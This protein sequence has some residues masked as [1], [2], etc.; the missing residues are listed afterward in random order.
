M[1]GS[2]GLAAAGSL[3]IGL[4]PTYGT[5]GV[6]ASALLVFARLVQGL[7]HGGELPAAQT[8]VAEMAPVNGEGSGRA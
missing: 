5:I 7:A 1:V 8:Y 2:I 6:G 4:A 3:L